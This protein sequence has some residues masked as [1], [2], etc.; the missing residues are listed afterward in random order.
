[1]PKTKT[2]EETVLE[3]TH[4]LPDGSVVE[5]SNDPLTEEETKEYELAICFERDVLGY[6]L[7]P[8]TAHTPSQKRSFIATVKSVVPMKIVVELVEKLQK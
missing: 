4:T 5:F 8:G 2:P 7:P 1:M 3:M 6:P